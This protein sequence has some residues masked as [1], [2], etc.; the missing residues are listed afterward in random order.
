MTDDK[1]PP[2]LSDNSDDSDENELPD[3]LRD[4]NDDSPKSPN[5]LGVTGELSWMQD[6][7]PS[8]DDTP[9]KGRASTGLTGELSWNQADETPN[10]LKDVDDVPDWLKGDDDTPSNQ[11]SAQFVGDDDETL[12]DWLTDADDDNSGLPDWLDDATL[13]DSNPVN[14]DDFQLPEEDEWQKASAFGGN[15]DTSTWGNFEGTGDTQPADD[16]EMEEAFGASAFTDDSWITETEPPSLEEDFADLFTD[17][18]VSQFSPSDLPTTGMLFGEDDFSDDDDEETFDLLGTPSDVDNLLG[19]DDFDLLGELNDEPSLDFDLFGE[20]SDEPETPIADALASDEKFL[21]KFGDDDPFAD[22]DVDIDALLG[23]EDEAD[24]F[25]EFDAT[26]ANEVVEDDLS[27]L[28]DISSVPFQ[29]TRPEPLFTPE[30]RAKLQN[31]PLAKMPEPELDI[32]SYLAS[33]DEVNVIPNMDLESAD[34]DFETLFEDGEE[35]SIGIKGLS[36][37]A[38]SWLTDLSAVS[39]G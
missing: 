37:D 20:L 23:E 10:F 18:P 30:T 5:R 31:Q 6:D 22:E 12:P 24:P 28:E 3:W 14:M 15:V 36:P 32:E 8:G 17:S 7:A 1:L 19:G 29:D 38:P 4:D 21:A 35:E 9:K 11:L 26:P 13:G 2:W 27:W 34:L 16:D 33:L 25:R 39:A